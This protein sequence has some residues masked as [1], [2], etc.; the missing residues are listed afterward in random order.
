MPTRQECIEAA[1]EVI[2]NAAVRIETERAV[3]WADLSM[4]RRRSLTRSVYGCWVPEQTEMA[5]A[6][7]L[8]AEPRCVYPPHLA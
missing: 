1:A 7:R 8:C 3:A 5:A 4:A 2:L 6:R